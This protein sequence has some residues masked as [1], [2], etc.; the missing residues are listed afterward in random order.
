[1]SE[2]DYVIKKGQLNLVFA[3]VL[4][5]NEFY[6]TIK[7]WFLNN[8]YDLEEKEYTKE[9]SDSGFKYTIE[10]EGTKK[11]D[12]YSQY[13]IKVKIKFLNAVKEK[14][15][16]E[17]GKL[18]VGFISYNE[19]DYEDKWEGPMLKKFTRGLFDK[20][21]GKDKFVKYEEE[22]KEETHD[23]FNKMK[24]FLNLQKFR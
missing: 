23:L 10:F 6:T 8:G 22:L 16:L 3:G 9:P 13:H 15:T 20:F 21:F 2:K 11:I 18:N 19:S 4:S 17:K 12:D 1:M 7:E 24:S 5:I 14:R